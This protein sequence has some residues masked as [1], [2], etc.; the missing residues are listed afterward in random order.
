VARLSVDAAGTIGDQVFDAA[1]PDVFTFEELVRLV[2]EAVGS[3]A[4]FVHARL[5]LTNSLGALLGAVLR[6][7][8]I[9]G[10]ELQGLMANLLTSSA[11][12]T[13]KRRFADWLS[14]NA[15]DLGASYTSERRRNWR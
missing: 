13:G 6:D 4:R 8:L 11:P 7:T 14:A 3:R 10:A 15:N 9:T 5:D 12:P 1:G 2:R